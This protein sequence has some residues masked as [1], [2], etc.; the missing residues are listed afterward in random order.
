[1][2]GDA[3]I[4]HFHI[5]F[6]TNLLFV[7]AE[8]KLIRDAL[9][10]FI[11]E[12]KQS[13]PPRITWHLLDIVRAERRYQMLQVA[14]KLLTQVDKVGKLLGKD[15]GITKRNLEQGI[16]SVIA[17]EVKR[18]NL[19]IRKLDTRLVDW[20]AL[21]ER[22]TSRDPPFEA[23]KTEK[24]FRDC[25]VLETFA[26]LVDELSE[27]KARRIV[28]MTND[29]PLKDAVH[30]R[31]KG[32]DYVS[33]V[34]DIQ[35]IKSMLNAY[36]SHIGGH[37]LEVLLERAQQLFY[38]EDERDSL[39]Y[40]WQ[41]EHVIR[42]QH[43]ASLLQP[44]P[45]SPAWTNVTARPS[46]VGPTTFIGKIDQQLTFATYVNFEVVAAVPAY[47]ADPYRATGFPYPDLGVSSFPTAGTS[48]TSTTSSIAPSTVSA[49]S[50]FLPITGGTAA[51]GLF[52]IT[53]GSAASN[54]F[55][56][57]GSAASGLFPNT[58]TS[59]VGTNVLNLSTVGT[60]ATAGAPN[61]MFQRGIKVFEVKWRAIL[62]QTDELNDPL[63]HEIRLL[64]ADW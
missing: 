22:S 34:P 25:I 55:P 7:E 33:T 36:A 14:L 56:I 42:D 28:L 19:K 6:D 10:E 35:T 2:T 29:G 11:L 38:R 1:M 24:G 21:I 47:S 15:F 59:G 20:S 9:S 40:K 43:R 8:N 12:R 49:A 51:T 52:P 17:D 60:G 64:S 30:E 4:P 37:E 50:G 63:L 48:F 41:I 53:G 18:H 13:E 3:R 26:Q 27:S 5:A 46:S 39:F 23:G 44:P 58:G 16:D 57:T 31:M 45:F 62:G 32:K 54:L 61:F